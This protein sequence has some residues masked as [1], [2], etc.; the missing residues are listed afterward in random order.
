MNK[1]S[2]RVLFYAGV[3]SLAA[4]IWAA[5][6]HA[7]EAHPPASPTP[8]ADIASPLQIAQAIANWQ[9]SKHSSTY[10]EGLGAD[11]TCARCKSPLNWDPSAP[12]A[13]AALDCASCKR[14]PGEPRPLLE[15]GVPVAEADWQHIG[16]PVCHEPV[17]S[18]YR[19]APAFWNQALGVYESVES[20]EALCAHCHEGRHGFEVIEE[21]R[22]DQAHPGWTCLDC[23]DPHGG[24]VY[25][26]DCHDATT[27]PA[28]EEHGN[29]Q[30][31]HCTACHDAGGLGLWRDYDAQSVYVGTVITRRFAH[32][33]TSWPSHNL[34]TEVD[35]RRCHHLG[36]LDRPA[37]SQSVS[38][39]NSGCHPSGA[40]LYWCPLFPQETQP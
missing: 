23:H 25:C 3:L 16:C 34:R 2:V 19:I 38:C 35:C 31:V 13:E 1:F 27:G 29:H 36:N 17:G 28:A 20:A 24:A 6:L 30:E 33:L 22:A 10:D 5:G 32:T 26:T 12:A 14:I 15:G 9:R 21:V 18:S 8:S 37:L 40:V 4:G 7:Q 39:Q 11:T